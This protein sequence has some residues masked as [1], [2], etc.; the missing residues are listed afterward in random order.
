MDAVGKGVIA[1]CRGPGKA[2][3]PPY[4]HEIEPALEGRPEL[5]RPATIKAKPPSR[6]A[7][8]APSQNDDSAHNGA[9]GEVKQDTQETNGTQP[10][11]SHDVALST[12]SSTG[13]KPLL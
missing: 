11:M 4:Q 12:I 10:L 7:A 8:K 2:I 3:I 6:K 9:R 13:M 1:A 5:A